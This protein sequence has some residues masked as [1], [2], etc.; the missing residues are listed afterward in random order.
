MRLWGT[1]LFVSCAYRTGCLMDGSP[2]CSR[3]GLHIYGASRSLQMRQWDV[4]TGQL[5]RAFKPH[6]LPVLDLATDA[7][8]MLLVRATA[9]LPDQLPTCCRA[10]LG[11][12]AAVG[13]CQRPGGRHLLSRVFLTSRP[14]ARNS[15]YCSA[16]TPQLLRAQFPPQATASADRTARVWDAIRGYCTHAFKG[17]EAPVQTVI[18]HP[19]AAKLMLFTGSDDTQVR[20]G[21]AAPSRSRARCQCPTP[22]SRLSCVSTAP[23]RLLHLPLL[24]LAGSHLEPHDEGVRR[25]AE[26]ALLSRHVALR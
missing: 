17:H 5:V 23:A 4:A 13:H 8:G 18:F 25:R 11:A 24:A 14:N 3:D 20:R 12:A 1:A 22:E 6:S 26:V 10:E 2:N 19:D 21:R 16:H 9:E 7:S 15:T